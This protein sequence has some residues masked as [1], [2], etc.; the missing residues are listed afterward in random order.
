MIS[1]KCTFFL[2]LVTLSAASLV[3]PSCG[4]YSSEEIQLSAAQLAAIRSRATSDCTT[5]NAT[6]FSELLAKFA[7][8]INTKTEMGNRAYYKVTDVNNGSSVTYDLGIYK[9]Y[10][11]KIYFITKASPT[12]ST[13]SHDRVYVFTLADQLKYFSGT[14]NLKTTICT[15]PNTFNPVVQDFFYTIKDTTPDATDADRTEDVIKYTNNSSIPLIFSIFN[16]D[17]TRTEYQNNA[18]K[19]TTKHTVSMARGTLPANSTLFDETTFDSAYHCSF[20]SVA[21]WAAVSSIG[22]DFSALASCTTTASLLWSDVNPAA[23]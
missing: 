23:N 7:T 12:N 17:Y 16:Y 1:T 3:L 19:T 9:I 2:L 22:I 13:P 21:D 6:F 4:S 8:S 11:N 5:K 10:S 20:S 15:S 18:I 14:D